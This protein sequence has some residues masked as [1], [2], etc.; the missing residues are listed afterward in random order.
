[1]AVASPRVSR[2]PRWCYPPRCSCRPGEV[3][4]GHQ[5]S[6]DQARSAGLFA[7]AHTA[8]Y[9]MGLLPNST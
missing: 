4:V 7:L 8:H 3:G 6:H 2:K 9:V 1:M 5:P